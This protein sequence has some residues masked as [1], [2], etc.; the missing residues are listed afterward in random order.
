MQRLPGPR[1]A[2]VTMSCPT[3]HIEVEARLLDAALPPNA[4]VLDAGCGRTTRLTAHRDRI[5]RLVGIDLD[6]TA[7]AENHGIDES[8]VGDLC[9]PL[10]FPDA[11]FDAVYA[12]FVIEHLGAP[13]RAFTEWR[14]VLKPRGALIALTSNSANP[15]V[16]ASALLPERAR[17]AIKR[18]GAG[19]VERDVIPAHYRANRLGRLDDLLRRSGF[20]P[21]DVVHAATLHRY[22][23]RAPRIEAAIRTIEGSLPARL[24]ATIVAWYAAI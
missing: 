10:P 3:S 2:D 16:A 5:S 24:G 6:R 13:G 19:A 4:C 18:V 17:V 7:L 21:V 11:T 23:A 15:L 8:V 12:N 20:A 14:R 1:L 22:M 9:E